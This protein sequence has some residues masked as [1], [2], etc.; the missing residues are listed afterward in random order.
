MILEQTDSLY[1]N[2]AINC[3]ILQYAWGYIQE[4]TSINVHVYQFISVGISFCS[5]CVCEFMH[6]SA[7]F[8]F[9][10]SLRPVFP[11]C[12]ISYLMEMPSVI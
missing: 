1:K 5:V 4:C 11:N 7:F 3:S 6:Q 8:S 10:Q 9:V 12:S 2:V